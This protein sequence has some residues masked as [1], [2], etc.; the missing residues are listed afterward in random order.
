M[1]LVGVAGSVVLARV[2][3]DAF[4]GD[5]PAPDRARTTAIM[6]AM[7][8]ACLCLVGS[9]LV[10]VRPRVAW[11]RGRSVGRADTSRRV[12]AKKKLRTCSMKTVTRPYLPGRKLVPP[13]RLG[14]GI[15]ISHIW[16][17]EVS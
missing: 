12:R 5:R 6:T 9:E 3:D 7:L 13:V 11:R 4:R 2:H 16:Q 14:S 8:L 15:F 17:V 1:K 10:L